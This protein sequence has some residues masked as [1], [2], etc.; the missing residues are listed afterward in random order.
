MKKKINMLVNKKFLGLISAGILLW[1]CNSDFAK[2]IPEVGENEEINVT[3]GT[4]K[5]LLLVVDGARGESVRTANVPTINSILPKSIYSFVSLSEDNS[6]GIANN[7]ADL[8]TGVRKNKHNVSSDFATNNFESYPLLFDRIINKEADAKLKM[9]S[10]SETF[11]EGLGEHNTT[12]LSGSDGD[13]TNNIISALNE[14]D[15]TMIT[16]HYTS[17]DAAGAS[18]VYDNSSA[19]YKQAIENFDADFSKIL[20]AVKA[21]ANYESENWLIVVTSSQGGEFQLPDSQNDNTIFSVP[22]VNTF[23][24]YH[25]L[26]YNLRFIGKPYIGNRMVGDY[27]RFNDTKYAELVEGDNTI[28][29]LGEGEF[30]VELK[31]KKNKGPN[32]TYKFNYASVLGKRPYWQDGWTNDRNVRGWVIYLEENYWMFNAGGTGATAQVKGGVLN[33]ASWNSISAVGYM[34]EGKRF[35]KTYTN[36]VANEDI[37]ISGW[38]N[39]DSDA[40]LRFGTLPSTNTWKP[41]VYLADVRIWKVGLPEE[42]IK[43][44]S[45]EVGLDNRHPYIDNLAG[46]WSVLGSDG[47]YILDESPYGGK[48]KLGGTGY[49]IERLNDYICAPSVADLGLLV[50]R[51]PDI[52]AQIFSWLKV[53]RQTNWQLDGR[54]W[55]D[56]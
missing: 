25:A 39:I 3:Y 48:L 43:Q 49:Q 7:W 54:V 50:P 32:N 29:N 47:E 46:S 13:V 15:I 36:G 31:I 37:D 42:V 22:A 55:L 9:F 8:F 16:G 56:K 38:G 23:T 6:M 12:T 45:C 27:I 34:K 33:N 19:A 28:Y 52:S 51:N 21:R 41:D 44:F 11:L 26:S 53:P 2:V 5:V 40:L 17:V 35:L 30:T 24:I 20:T 18:S 10:T 1:S 4:P 14:D